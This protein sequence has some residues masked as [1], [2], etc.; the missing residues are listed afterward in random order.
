MSATGHGAQSVPFPKRNGLAPFAFFLYYHDQLSAKLVACAPAHTIPL[1]RYKASLALR[2]PSSR[3][4]GDTN[5]SF[6]LHTLTIHGT[7]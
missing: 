2:H 7:I 3:V 4:I 6:G 5:T 1:W